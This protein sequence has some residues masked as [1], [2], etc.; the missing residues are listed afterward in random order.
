VARIGD[1]IFL[2]DLCDCRLSGKEESE[3]KRT[4]ADVCN[5]CRL[6]PALRAAIKQTFDYLTMLDARTANDHNEKSAAALLK[7]I[8]EVTALSS[9]DNNEWIAL[10]PVR[11]EHLAAGLIAL[12]SI[13][14]GGRRA[15]QVVEAMF[16]IRAK[17][18]DGP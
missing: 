8:L 6:S 15:L 4:G 13:V 2:C 9:C 18:S 1:D 16:A 11:N 17:G 3:A 14:G 10:A 12:A 5:Y 7:R